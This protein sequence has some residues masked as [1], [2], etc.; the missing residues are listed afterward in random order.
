MIGSDILLDT[1]AW[2]E[3]LRGS[4]NGAVIRRRFLR[5]SGVRLH[6]STITV[7]EI[8]AKLASMGE[9][10]RID[11]VIAAIRRAGRLHDVTTDLA[12][13][14]GILRV[15]LRKSDA[16][17]SLADGIVLATARSLGARLIS[18]D[19]AFRGQSDVVGKL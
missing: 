10:R 8:S 13:T 6:T 16:Q 19:A 14:A 18:A 11:G 9:A 4:R 3:L 17:A 15:E 12:R 1:W 5:P 2:W 7:G